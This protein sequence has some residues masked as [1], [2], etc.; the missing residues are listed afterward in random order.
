MGREA[1]DYPVPPLGLMDIPRQNLLHTRLIENGW[2]V[3]CGDHDG[4]EWYADEYWIIESIWS[5]FGLQ[6]YLTF[7]VDPMIDGHRKDGQVVWAVGT[8]KSK[9]ANRIEAEGKPLMQERAR[10]GSA[11]TGSVLYFTQTN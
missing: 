7:L 9:P 6:L 10:T 5:P 4:L 3:I 2:K 1:L 8:S 11:R